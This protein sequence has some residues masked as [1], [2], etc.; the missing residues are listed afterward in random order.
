MRNDIFIADHGSTRE[1]VSFTRR[2]RA[3]LAAVAAAPDRAG[4]PGRAAPWASAFRLI[5]PDS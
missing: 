2:A 4:V 1:T 5:V 3:A